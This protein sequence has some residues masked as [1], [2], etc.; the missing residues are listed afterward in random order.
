MEKVA[1]R[2][3]VPPTLYTFL[4][5]L[6]L[7]SPLDVAAYS[8]LVHALACIVWYILQLFSKCYIF[9]HQSSNYTIFC[10]ANLPFLEETIFFSVNLHLIY[11][12]LFFSSRNLKSMSDQFDGGKS[13]YSMSASISFTYYRLALAGQ[14]CRGRGS[15]RTAQPLFIR[16]IIAYKL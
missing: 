5:F 9:A 1:Q 3:P 7:Y 13:F 11:N 8:T 15:P 10:L 16:L 14:L 12:K 6:V 4:R 2:V